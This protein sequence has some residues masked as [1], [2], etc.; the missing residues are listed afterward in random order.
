MATM[1][2]VD[3]FSD[4]SMLDQQFTAWDILLFLF[5][6]YCFT[7]CVYLQCNVCLRVHF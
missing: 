2:N 4:M 7:V 3:I 1:K 6:K 5:M